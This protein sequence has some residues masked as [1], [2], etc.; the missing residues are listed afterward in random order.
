MT[1]TVTP[2]IRSAIMARVRSR[3]NA[4]TELRMAR[5]LRAAQLTG[6][7]RHWPVIGRPDFAFPRE[8]VA[9]FVDGCF[10]HGCPRCYRQ[11]KSSLTYWRGKV[12][13]NRERDRKV[14][15]ALRA[16]GW[17]V[18]RVWECQLDRPARPL[19]ALQRRLGRAR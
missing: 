3:G 19:A 18:V 2:R 16:S 17:R 5:L 14:S 12:T 4:S 1:D 11:P 6:W 13:R 8:K 9:L 10:W 7:R 15:A